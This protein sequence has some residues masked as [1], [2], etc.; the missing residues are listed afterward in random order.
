MKKLDLPNLLLMASF[1]I[2]VIACVYNADNETKYRHQLPGVWVSKRLPVV[3]GI[4]VEEYTK[5]MKFLTSDA[6]THTIFSFRNDGRMSYYPFI[7]EKWGYIP[8]NKIDGRWTIRGNT[9]YISQGRFSLIPMYKVEFADTFLVLR[10]TRQMQ[11]DYLTALIQE[12]EE[13]LSSSKNQIEILDCSNVRSR[14]IAVLDHIQRIQG[15]YVVT[16]NYTLREVEPTEINT[17]LEMT[18]DLPTKKEVRPRYAE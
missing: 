9:L 11:E 7:R 5:S 4:P 2:F 8:G 12:C 14:A 6:D 3:E 15:N 1:S 18:V 13:R 10:Q 17:D 16:R